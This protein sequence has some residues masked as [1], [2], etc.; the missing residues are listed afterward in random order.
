MNPQLSK[1]ETFVMEVI[2]MEGRVEK[3]K[4]V[5]RFLK[6]NPLEMLCLAGGKVALDEHIQLMIDERRVV[7]REDGSEMFIQLP[8]PD[9][10]HKPI[11][12]QLADLKSQLDVFIAYSKTRMFNASDRVIT[13]SVTLYVK[14]KMNIDAG[15][16]ICV[17]SIDLSPHQQNKG[18][19]KQ[20]AVHMEKLAKE[21]FGKLEYECVH[22]PKLEE[23]LVKHGY[24]S[25][26]PHDIVK[27]Y[28]KTF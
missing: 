5:D 17:G 18:L 10:A 8:E 20:L 1:I 26:N 9:V 27:S 4:V 21:H 14:T 15:K 6:E 22:N 7:V 12:A 19:F 2:F 13:D 23:M 11:E 28:I 3:D 16:H 24:Q 25:T